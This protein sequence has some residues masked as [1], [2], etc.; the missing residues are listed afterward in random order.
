MA[1]LEPLTALTDLSLVHSVVGDAGIKHIAGI[2]KLRKLRLSQTRL[3]DKGL[4]TLANLNGVILLDLD[5]TAVSDA[6][7]CGFDAPTRFRRW[8][9]REPL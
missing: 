9:Y 5:S 1:S 3:T 7:F 2:T 4:E 6:G 8:T